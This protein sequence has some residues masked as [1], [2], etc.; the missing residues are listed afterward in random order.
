MINETTQSNEQV[1]VARLIAFYLPQ[2]HPI[3]ENDE[4]WG[5]GFTEWTNTAKAKPLFNGHYQ[6]HI[7]ADL[8]FYDLRVPETRAAQ[9]AMARKYGIEAFCYYHYWFA[10]RR[11]LE[12][13]FHEVLHSG[14]PDFPFCLCWA[15]QTWTG[16]WHG[17]PNRVLVEQTYPGMEDHRLHFE[18]LLPAF[19]DKR[20]LKV[21]GKPLFVVHEPMDISD[22]RR[23]MDFWRELALKN[24]LPG[25]FLA[26]VHPSQDWDPKP[27]GYDTSVMINQWQWRYKGASWN[28]PFKKIKGKFNQWRGIPKVYRYEQVVDHLIDKQMPGIENFPCVIPNW[29]N[30]PRSGVNGL[31]FHGST[32]EMFRRHL[33]RALDR[34]RDVPREHRIVFV[35]SWN[36]WAEGNHLEP[37]LRFGLGYLE[38]LRE[39]ILGN[40]V[41]INSSCM[42]IVT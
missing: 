25:L 13:P 7:P 34:M 8:G 20:H 36:E 42:S 6:P 33:R 21:D 23:V 41:K 28:Q 40:Q 16:I 17:E 3:P 15:N 22:S 35:K 30:T 26:A 24:G 14:E 27:Y 18:T 19:C 32:P 10:G 37:D 31:V 5:R 39:E 38:V 2:F 12:R 9:A 4:W 29:D 11:L 1:A